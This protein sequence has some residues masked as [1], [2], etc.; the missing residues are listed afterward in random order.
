MI[1]WRAAADADRQMRGQLRWRVALG[2]GLT[3][4]ATGLL[5]LL[6]WPWLL[7][8]V[9]WLKWGRPEHPA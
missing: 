2:L 6:A 5:L 7:L 4:V 8:R 3:G 9:C 1:C